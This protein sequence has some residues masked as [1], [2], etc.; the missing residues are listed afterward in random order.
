MTR[1]NS[2]AYA[3]GAAD[4]VRDNELTAHGETPIGPQPPNPKYPLMYLRGYQ[5]HRMAANNRPRR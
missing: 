5:E 3:Q 2:P 1:E 4:A